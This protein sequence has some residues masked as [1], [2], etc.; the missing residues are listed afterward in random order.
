MP[1]VITG[2]DLERDALD[3]WTTQNCLSE[4][5]NAH[6]SS[7]RYIEITYTEGG[8]DWRPEYIQVVYEDDSFDKC[9]INQ[10]FVRGTRTV[11]C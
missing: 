6:I 3:V 2:N 11:Y 8:D 4:C 10:N 1:F 7:L 5:F 9:Y